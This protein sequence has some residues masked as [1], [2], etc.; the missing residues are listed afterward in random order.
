M[1]ENEVQVW[2]APLD[3]A[4]AKLAALEISLD[5]AERERAS[6]F[7]FERDRSRFI[8]AHGALREILA[9]ALAIPPGGIAF[10]F[11][12]AGKPRLVGDHSVRFSLSHSGSLA[13]IAL[14]DN[15]E[16]GVDVELIRDLPEMDDIA[17]QSF[18]PADRTMLQGF[19]SAKKKDFFFRLWTRHEAIAKCTGL[20]LEESNQLFGG[21]VMELAPAPGC[22]GAVAVEHGEIDVRFFRW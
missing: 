20:G 14:A 16:I 13:L 22:I 5:A 15:R 11:G 4:P 1:R 18:S 21:S 7:H 6:R 19:D 12:P 3:L 2:M 8:A 9:S 17:R 10:A